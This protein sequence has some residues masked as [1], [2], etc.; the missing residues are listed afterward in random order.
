LCNK[1]EDAIMVR[2]IVIALAAAGAIIA[3]SAL[4]ASARMGGMGGHGGMSMGH[5]SMG[6][7]H[8][9]M[10]MGR[11]SIGSVGFARMGG[12]GISRAAFVGRSAPFARVAVAHPRFAFRDHRFR[13]RNRFIFAAAFPYGYYDGCYERIWTRWGWR[14]V[15]VCGPYAY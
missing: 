8:G 6:M 10:G 1:L 9:S 14:L 15:N 11:A 3:G 12:P 13:F 2:K 5:G 4:D 7:G